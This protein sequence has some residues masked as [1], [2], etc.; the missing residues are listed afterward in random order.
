MSYHVRHHILSYHILSLQVWKRSG[1]WFFKGLPKY[2]IPEKKVEGPK[3]GT[4]NNKGKVEYRGS[5]KGHAGTVRTYNNWSRGRGS[6]GNI[7][8]KNSC[9]VHLV[10]K[11]TNLFS[12]DLKILKLNLMKYVSYGS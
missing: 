8:R 1:A 5:Q 4:P 9:F 7:V 2:V 11:L 6:Q 12:F 3:H 10:M